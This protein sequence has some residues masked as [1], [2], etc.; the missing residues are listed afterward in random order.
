MTDSVEKSKKLEMP[1]VCT[2]KQADNDFINNV[3]EPKFNKMGSADYVLRL[4]IQSYLQ[5]GDVIPKYRDDALY[6]YYCYFTLLGKKQKDFKI[7]GN[8]T[9][10][11]CMVNIDTTA[12]PNEGKMIWTCKVIEKGPCPPTVI[13][14]DKTYLDN[15]KFVE[16]KYEICA[17]WEVENEQVGRKCVTV[18]C[19][20]KKKPEHK[21]DLIISCLENCLVTPDPNVP[22]RLRV[23]DRNTGQPPK[24]NITWEIR[25]P[26]GKTISLGDV[27]ISE[28]VKPYEL[29]INVTKL[30]KCVAYTVYAQD[31]AKDKIIPYNIEYCPNEIPTEGN[32]TM[33]PKSGMKGFTLFDI[34]CFG[35]QSEGP[36]LYEFFDKGHDDIEHYQGRM[37]GYSYSGI[38]S[39]FRLTRGRVVIYLLNE[40]GDGPSVTINVELY[41]FDRNITH[42]E[43]L[44][45][46]IDDYMGY[47]NY[48][49][50]QDLMST[51][52]EIL[53]KDLNN[54][55][56]IRRIISSMARIEYD[57]AESMKLG[58]STI[59]SVLVNGTLKGTYLLDDV[60]EMYTGRILLKLAKVY[61][62]Y[63]VKPDHTPRLRAKH[64][65]QLSR[66]MMDCVD[67][68]VIAQDRNV[69]KLAPEE[70][71]N[72]DVYDNLNVASNDMAEALMI[73]M[74][75]VGRVQPY[76][77]VG[78]QIRST[79]GVS[80]MY[81]YVNNADG[82]VDVAGSNITS[83][84]NISKSLANTFD[85]NHD[86]MLQGLMCALHCRWVY[87]WVVSEAPSLRG[88]HHRKT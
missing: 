5:T 51:L 47:N 15:T 27:I 52:A 28:G 1:N 40:D 13:V 8:E 61:L 84:V 11:A 68:A 63:A 86:L 39:Q 59:L 26:D 2:E 88:R 87:Q 49:P 34:T 50:T 62:K 37:T 9:I 31:A 32:C 78:R 36:I 83:Y 23:I 30:K 56:Y 80:E 24:T 42:I 45:N 55:Y 69:T 60:L 67:M 3:C 82:L 38:Y 41:D 29:K 19:K 66:N 16:G 4:T 14:N 48:Q 57:S 6:N 53:Y 22:V 12:V 33:T 35:W 85:E 75:L 18:V 17:I 10:N 79:E 73:S 44:M 71:I 7:K 25:D 65:H 64:V 72:Y 77:A 43:Y 54:E 58:I 20:E 81:S 46:E 21:P 70:N 76:G 74:Y